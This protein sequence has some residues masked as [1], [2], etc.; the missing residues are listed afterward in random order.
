MTAAPEEPEPTDALPQARVRRDRWRFPV[1]WVV[2]IIAAIVAAYLVYGRIQ[3]FGPTI[4]IKFREANGV[5]ASQTEVRYRGVPIGEATGIELSADHQYVVVR[6]RLRRWAFSIAKADSL[7]WIVRPEVGIRSISG[8][9]TVIT[10]PF[11]QV[12][13]GT[14][15]ARTE[16]TGLETAPPTLGRKGLKVTLAAARLGSVKP[17]SPVHYRGFEVGFV[18]DTDLS[19]DATAAQI[20]VF[21]EQRYAPLVR[22]G[23]RFWDVSGVD[24]NISLLRGVQISLESLRSLVA[25][26]I[27]FATPSPSSPPVKDGAIFPLHEKPQKEWLEW[28]PKIPVSPAS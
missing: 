22:V 16:F 2:P 12:Y 24:V 18:T 28:T 1:V 19:R 21:I 5:K 7:F 3:E 13:P 20:H 14:G 15:E 27:A 26:G 11:I 10:G 6:A 9:S 25:G 8:L 4:T 23:S 17:G